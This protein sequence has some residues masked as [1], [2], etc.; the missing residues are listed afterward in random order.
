MAETLTTYTLSQRLDLVAEPVLAGLQQMG[1]ALN[2]FRVAEID[3]AVS[4]S[5][6][7]CRHFGYDARR[8]A[9][10]VILEAVR[11]GVSKLAV[12]IVAAADRA[13]I[14][15]VVRKALDARRVS[16]APKDEAVSGSGME[17]GSITAI[18]LPDEW[19]K[20]VD[21]RL[22]ELPEV[23]MGGGF[24]RSKILFPG[25]LLEKLPGAR[26]LENLVRV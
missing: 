6:V 14:N 13:D 26:V 12:V 4:D 8:C 21:S 19:P 22:L 16:L 20:L 7:F 18:G 3:P 15:G 1:V 25:K 11:G 2:E 9:N 5:E 17:F 10:T 23:L 24:R